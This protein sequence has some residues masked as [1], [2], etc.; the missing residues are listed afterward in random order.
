MKRAR[1][2]F[3]P[4]CQCRLSHCPNHQFS[5]NDPRPIQGRELS[6]R[7][8]LNDS[9]PICEIYTNQ[10]NSVTFKSLCLTLNVLCHS[11][12]TFAFSSEFHAANLR[13][14]ILTNK[15][16]RKKCSVNGSFLKSSF[17][18]HYNILLFYY[19]YKYNNVM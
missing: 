12:G 7:C 2:Y 5:R 15:L 11:S 6:F 4:T 3:W 16:F 8:L 9:V 1:T 10:I 18:H 19:S 14:K 17:S 13:K